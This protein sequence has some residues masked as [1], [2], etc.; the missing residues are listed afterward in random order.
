M[1]GFSLA[2]FLIS[3]LVSLVSLPVCRFLAIK[4][5]VVDRPNT[6]IKTHK[7]TTPYLGGV[8]IWLGWISGLL[9]ARLTT[10]FPTGTLTS[11]RGIIIG[12][13]FVTLIGL[14]DDIIPKGLHFSQ[15]FILDAVATFFLVLYHIRIHFIQPDYIAI[16]LTFFWVVGITNAFNIIDIMDGLSSSTAFIA[17]LAFLFISFP[18]E[19]MYVNFCAA[20]LAGAIL[21][22]I[23]FNL[24]SRRK[25]FMGDTGSLTIGFILAALSLGTTY[26]HINNIGVFAPVLILAIP[27]FDTFLVIYA[28]WRKGQLPFLGSK[29]HYALRLEKMGYTRKQILVFTV[30]AN[31]I[32]AEF[33]YL[34]VNLSWKYSLIIYILTVVGALVLARRLLRVNIQ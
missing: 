2:T 24:S 3:F 7:K 30:I 4:Y 11:L 27:I 13:S 28:R 15:K 16:L 18:T 23:P 1:T 20:A 8:A 21:A 17:A 26:T 22:F 29:D 33:A 12:S 25:I 9:F 10:N 19:Q 32:L 31:I 5:R 14:I 6:E 34:V